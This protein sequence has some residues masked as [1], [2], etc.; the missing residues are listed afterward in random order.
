MGRTQAV[1]GVGFGGA[2]SS[3]IGRLRSMSLGPYEWDD[4]IVIVSSATEGA[5]ASEEFAGNIGNRV[6]E[7]FRVTFDYQRREV[8]LEPGRH[9]SDRDRL[10]R[11]GMLLTR[12]DGTVK[13]ASVLANSPADHA[14]LREGDQVLALDGRDI[15]QWDLP[16]VSALLDDGEIGSKVAVR[17]RRNEAEKSLKIKL[18]EVIR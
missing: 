5:F 11:C 14:G 6:L 2:F 7:R 9:Y 3:E 15:A 10:T 13:V 1:D 8:V 17:M 18:A 4:P 16:A 12:R